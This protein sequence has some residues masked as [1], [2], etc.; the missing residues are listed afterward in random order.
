MEA[1]V[2]RKI[3]DMLGH[4]PE[5]FPESWTCV[6]AGNRLSV[7]KSEKYP[8]GRHVLLR[9][10]VQRGTLLGVEQQWLVALLRNENDLAL[11]AGAELEAD[12]YGSGCFHAMFRNG[13]MNDAIAFCQGG[14]QWVTEVP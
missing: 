3:D 2:E 14:A 12:P 9:E 11:A 10:Y 1:S 7:W 5:L 8:N 4:E 6:H 13:R